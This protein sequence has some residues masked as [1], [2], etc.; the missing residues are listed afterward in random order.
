MDEE[1]NMRESNWDLLGLAVERGGAVRTGAASSVRFRGGWQAAGLV[2]VDRQR[3]DLSRDRAC[4]A[5]GLLASVMQLGAQ[6]Q[7][8][9]EPRKNTRARTSASASKAERLAE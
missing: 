2:R 8:P 5:V 9:Q 6:A 3:R 7:A 1:K 4:T